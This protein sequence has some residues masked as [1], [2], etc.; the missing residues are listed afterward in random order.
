MFR[1]R[2]RVN[3][4]ATGTTPIYS[5]IVG[6]LM[7]VMILDNKF[8]ET[9]PIHLRRKQFS[10]ARQKEGQSVIEF[11]EEILSLMDEADGANIGVNDLIYM[12]LQ[13]GV[14]D[15][16]LQRKLGSLRNPTLPSFNKKIEGYEEA[17]KTTSLSTAFGN[18]ASQG[19]PQRRPAGGQAKPFQLPGAARGRGERDC[20][21]A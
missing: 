18:A 4:E 6:L 16:I 14:S 20:R 8:L 5:P 15:P 21:L 3:R 9:N 2:A 17:R 12:M 13:I 10:D 7:C 1:R 19:N 11:R